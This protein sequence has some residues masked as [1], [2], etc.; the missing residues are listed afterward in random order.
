MLPVGA[1]AL[2]LVPITRH[3]LSHGRVGATCPALCYLALG[4]PRASV[5]RSVTLLTVT[6]SDGA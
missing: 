6:N 4:E 1:S 2:L 5:L 3:V